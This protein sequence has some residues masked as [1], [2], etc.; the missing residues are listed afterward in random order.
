MGEALF[1]RGGVA[2][3]IKSPGQGKGQPPY[4]VSRLG[5]DHR[6]VTPGVV[7]QVLHSV[8]MSW[9]A[10]F[11]V[12]SHLSR[13]SLLRVRVNITNETYLFLV[14]TIATDGKLWQRRLWTMAGAATAVVDSDCGWRL[15]TAAADNDDGSLRMK[16]M[17]QAVAGAAA[18]GWRAGGNRDEITTA[19]DDDNDDR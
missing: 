11:A 15:Q 1:N 3:T 6:G 16:T 5:A 2:Q 7:R 18:S 17:V 9:K 4:I 14:I 13:R 19:F 12:V 8:A 10:V